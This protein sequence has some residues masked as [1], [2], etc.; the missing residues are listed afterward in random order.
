[1]SKRRDVMLALKALVTAAV[2]AARVRGFDGDASKPR[3][4]DPGGD[5]IGHPGDPGEPEVDLSPVA[6]T[7]EHEFPIEVGAPY[8]AGD[9]GAAIDA[10][11][12]AIGAAIAADRTLGGLCLF[13]EAVAPEEHDR[14]AEGADASRWAG[15]AIVATYTTDDPLN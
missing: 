3:Q 7:Y 4:A 15:F 11:M 10:I 5:V 9:P 13:L 14:K 6:Y 2:P 12:G 8:G 1:M